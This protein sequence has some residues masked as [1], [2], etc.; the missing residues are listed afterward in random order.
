MVNTVYTIGYSGFK[1]EDFIKILKKNKIM[2]VID[3]RSS[4]YSQY[5]SDYNKRALELKLKSENI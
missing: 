5:H 2:V 3:V 4:H 1:I